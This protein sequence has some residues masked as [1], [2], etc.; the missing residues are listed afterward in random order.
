MP[1]RNNPPTTNPNSARPTPRAAGC[2]PLPPIPRW[3]IP[4]HTPYCTA[5]HDDDLALDTPYIPE[6][7]EV[8]I[9]PPEPAATEAASRYSLAGLWQEIDKADLLRAAFVALAAALLGFGL[10]WPS[11]H[12]PLVALIA[13]PIGAY[14]IFKESVE[15]VL[16]RRMSMELSMLI[17]VIAAALIGEWI[18]A[19]VIVIFVLVAEI[20]EDLTMDRGRDALTELLSFLPNTVQVMREGQLQPLPLSEVTTNDVL[21]VSPGGSIPVDGVVVNGQSSV[22]QSRITGEP[23]PVDVREGS[24]VFAG[25]INQVGALE[26]RAERVGLE[27]SYGQI[28]ASVQA[29]QEDEPPIQRLGDRVAAY[30]VYFALGGAILTYLLTRDVTATIS[31]IVVAGACGIAAGTPLAVLAAIARTARKGVFIKGGAHLESLAQVNTVLVD[32]TGTLTTGELSVTSVTIAPGVDRSEFLRLLASA[33]AYSEHPL[34]QAIV[35]FAQDAGVTLSLPSMFAYAPGYGIRAT[36]DGVQIAAGNTKLVKDAPTPTDDGSIASLVNVSLN[37]TYAGTVRLADTIRETSAQAV[38]DLQAMGIRVEMVT[39]DHPVAAQPVADK[40]GIRDVHAGLLPREKMAHIEA[41]RT[42][43]DRVVMVGDGVNDA[44]ALAK[45]NVGVAMGGGTGVAREGAD[46]IL[47]RSD[48]NDLVGAVTTAQ[49]ARRIIFFN[50]VGTIVVDLAGM[51]LAGVGLLTPIL[52]ALVHV[53][54]ESAFILNSARLIP[55]TS[56]RSA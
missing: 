56:K 8:A 35:R 30:L 37:G 18:T 46:V 45:A 47:I 38:R 40:L 1:L 55:F 29:A 20:L 23:L 25:S 42:K 10:D 36:V 13:L 12:Y 31:V 5:D 28:I 54:S 17:A 49:R 24:Q 15:S 22:D 52:A 19:L 53:G 33:E 11:A 14:P 41:L 39:G 26:V 16:E 4:I 34:G 43:G 48:L 7:T 21:V 51:A 9:T 50:L 2:D 44:P 6:R 32:K 27:S 3:D